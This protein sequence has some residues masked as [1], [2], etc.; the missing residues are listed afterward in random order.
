MGV[1]TRFKRDA[2]GFRKLVEL[3]ESTPQVRRQKMIDVGMQ[4]DPAYTERAMQYMI[5]FEDILKLPDM[6]LADVIAGVPPRMVAY[7]ISLMSDDIKN[8]FLKLS[9]PRSAAEIKDLLQ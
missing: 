4:E 5:T 6:E 7:S 9:H 2:N 8:K 3:L 1:Y